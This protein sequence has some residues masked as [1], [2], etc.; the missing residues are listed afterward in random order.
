MFALL[1]SGI[2]LGHVARIVV[3]ACLFALSAV[4]GMV[5]MR[6]NRARLALA[7]EATSG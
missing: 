7:G 3:A 4:R 6:N 2:A 5:L 1:G